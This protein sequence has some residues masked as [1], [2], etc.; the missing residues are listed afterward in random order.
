M[1]YCGGW[2]GHGMVVFVELWVDRLGINSSSIE[3]GFVVCISSQQLT[4]RSGPRKSVSDSPPLIKI[5]SFSNMLSSVS[6]SVWLSIM[7][8][9]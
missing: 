6:L 8:S 2:G 7:P 3:N 1:G 9:S 5:M 4:S